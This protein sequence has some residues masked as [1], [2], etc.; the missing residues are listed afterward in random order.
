MR[1]STK[2]ILFFSGI[3]IVFL[4]VAMYIGQ[5]TTVDILDSQIRTALENYT[6][7]TVDKLDRV[8]YEKYVDVKNIA[9]DPIIASRQST[10]VQITER[11]KS[12]QSTYASYVSM[13]F[14]TLDRVRIAD[15]SGK[16]IGQQYPLKGYWTQ[17]KEG[18]DVFVDVSFSNSTGNNVIRFVTYVKDREGVS[19]GVVVLK[20][21]M[22][23]L[24]DIV[25]SA[26]GDQ[27]N[28]VNMDVDLVNSEGMLLYSSDNAKGILKEI[29]PDWVFAKPLLLSG[30]SRGSTRHRHSDGAEEEILAFNRERGYGDF[31]GNNWTLM[32]SVPSKMA[33][34]PVRQLR[35]RMAILS[36]LFAIVGLATIYIFARRMTRPLETL[37]HGFS[38]VGKGNLD[39]SIDVRSKDE[40]GRMSL[41]FNT[42]VTELKDHSEKLLTYGI[43]MQ[44]NNVELKT[45]ARLLELRELE[46]G[47]FSRMSEL[48][49]ACNCVEEAGVVITN[50]VS[51]LFPRDRGALYIYNSSRNM[52]ESIS[53]WGN[54]PPQEL[55]ITQ[56]ECWG[57]RRGHVH[58]MV[59]DA[60]DIACQ[61]VREKG[62]PY[63]CTPI[64]AKGETIGMLHLLLDSLKGKSY[65]QDWLK[66]KEQLAM[67]LAEGCGLAIINLKLQ[68]SLRNM[69]MRDPL[70]GLFNR[71]Y[72]KESLELEWQ[73][74]M[75]KYTPIGIIMID[76][77]HF[78][79]FNDTFGH[80]GGDK[81]LCELGMFLTK[82]I[83]GG[84]IACRYGG[85]EFT[86]IMPESSAEVTMQRAEQIREA[87]CH[88]HVVY[89]QQSLG[90][91]TLSIGVAVLPVHGSDTNIVLQAADAALYR[92]KREGRN[93]VCMAEEVSGESVFTEVI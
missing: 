45:K 18:T 47:L 5:S 92:A 1:L 66:E 69:S 22:D 2:L 71:R 30:K 59:D 48:F 65:E 33:F 10:P 61:H 31:K 6:F 50:T 73:R 83:R 54:P 70:T 77:D 7:H 90:T 20:L 21:T 63:I 27:N 68:E 12:Y 64:M 37:S 15:T 4:T 11:L 85:E 56:N 60:R 62:V 28:D 75:R 44:K 81:L 14:F 19:F 93:R 16:D 87:A 17:L 86:I 57:L 41:A 39:I 3:G 9:R 72:M 26:K 43:D 24:D 74:S 78:K 23:V 49:Q 58:V 88:M 79:Q 55:V 13:S 51:Q 34:A 89:K 25:K 29:S 80:D 42:M 36:V 76:I 46:S 84:D 53:V 91:I 82:Q 8:L 38:E 67:R 52:L 40:I 32:M 35:V